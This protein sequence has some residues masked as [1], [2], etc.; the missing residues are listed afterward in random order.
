MFSSDHH[1]QSCQYLCRSVIRWLCFS[2]MITGEQSWLRCQHVLQVR[3]VEDVTT[4]GWGWGG[5]CLCCR[6]QLCECTC[7]PA[8][9]V[10]VCCFPPTWSISPFK[11]LLNSRQGGWR[12]C[13][14]QD[15][16]SHFYSPHRRGKCQGPSA[17]MTHPIPRCLVGQLSVA[18]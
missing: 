14:L 8:Q 6:L 1:W 13:Q 15:I 11:F 12:T 2:V 5:T 16:S 17:L 7:M 4:S 18:T 9:W 10:S 3:N